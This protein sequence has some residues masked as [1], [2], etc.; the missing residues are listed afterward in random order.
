MEDAHT[1]LHTLALLKSR[2][3]GGFTAETLR[4]HGN[5]SLV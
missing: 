4:G 5:L 1:G 3:S 2:L